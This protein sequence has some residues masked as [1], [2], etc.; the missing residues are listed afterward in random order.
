MNALFLRH[1]GFLGAVG[2]FLKVHP[3]HVAHAPASALGSRP[4]SGNRG[5][6][7]A[8]R[9]KVGGGC[10]L[11]TCGADGSCGSL[12]QTLPSLVCLGLVVW[13]CPCFENAPKL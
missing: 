11:W 4:N 3:M 7:R 5:V 10:W 2:A 8:H 9:S 12:A 13:H 1:E 6:T